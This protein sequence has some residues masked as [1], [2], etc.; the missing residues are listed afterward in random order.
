VSNYSADACFVEASGDVALAA[1][2]AFALYMDLCSYWFDL[3]LPRRWFNSSGVM[4]GLEY[5]RVSAAAGVLG[6]A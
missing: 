4:G 3:V 6:T 1:E 5:Q 2:S